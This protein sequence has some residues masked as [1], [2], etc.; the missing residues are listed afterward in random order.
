MSAE[1]SSVV[2]PYAWEDPPGTGCPSC[3]DGYA[4]LEGGVPAA[5]GVTFAAGGV[6]AAEIV[7]PGGEMPPN[8]RVAAGSSWPYD[9]IPSPAPQQM[10]MVRY[11]VSVAAKRTYE[12]KAV[13][14]DFVEDS[15]RGPNQP[16]RCH[17]LS[18]ASRWRQL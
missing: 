6:T 3:R 8:W 7:T 12:L 18:S 5:S 10:S 14:G 16:G 13:D 17:R 2:S 9:L 4:I 11:N 1:V 15:G